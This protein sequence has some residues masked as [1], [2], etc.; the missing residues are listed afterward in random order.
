MTVI[1]D[2]K[3]RVTLPTK[4]GERFDLQA[5]GKDKFLLTWLAPVRARPARVQIRKKNGYTVGTL[6]HAINPTALQK[7]LAAFP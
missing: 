1:A 6:N 2:N 5:L 4:P 7:A 3:G